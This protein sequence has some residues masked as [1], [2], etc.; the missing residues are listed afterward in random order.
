M[1]EFW[2]AIAGAFVGGLIAL[3]GQIVV[4]EAAKRARL[5][6]Q[7]DKHKA[8][9]HALLFKMIQIH[10]R[11]EKI[12]EHIQ[13]CVDVG[14]AKQAPA[15]PWQ[16]VMGL[17]SLPDPVHFTADEMAYLLSLKDDALFNDIASLDE[18]H[19]STVAAFKLFGD[20]RAA[21]TGTMSATMEGNVGATLFTTEQFA[22][23]RPRMVE[24]NNLAT[25]ILTAATTDAPLMWDAL[26]RLQIL[27]QKKSGLAYR[28]ELKAQP[29]APA[30]DEE[31]LT[32]AQKSA[33]R[34]PMIKALTG[35]Q[36]LAIILL[37]TSAASIGTTVWAH[38]EL[39]AQEQRVS[40]A[41]VAFDAAPPNLRTDASDVGRELIYANEQALKNTEFYLAMRKWT[42]LGHLVAALLVGMA[43]VTAGFLQH[44]RNEADAPT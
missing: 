4:L 8:L 34:A 15:E 26:N 39:Q 41:L 14:Q 38:G 11:I 23:A 3:A 28:V 24:L 31:T 35:F 25:S 33:Y 44:R 10:S 32:A 6:E 30:D 43:W 21:L 13:E 22:V 12:R 19:N 27:F 37:I 2:A 42:G 36:R 40:A 16:T 20:R 18:V 29:A 1:T 7:R 17:A 5:V 9:A